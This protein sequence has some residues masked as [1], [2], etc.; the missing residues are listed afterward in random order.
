MPSERWPGRVGVWVRQESDVAIGRGP[1]A[2]I[3]AIGVRLTRW[4]SSH[5]IA[6]N[7][8]P[9]LGHYAGIVPCGIADRGVTSLE[10]LLGQS[11]DEVEI[12]ERIA[13][14]FR[15]VFA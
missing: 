15:R 13:E 12:Q 6:L 5:G 7:V 11:I 2:K 10:R 1:R 3:A 4:V 8:A 9:D 14:H